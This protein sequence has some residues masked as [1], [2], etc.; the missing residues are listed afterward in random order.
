MVV[1]FLVRTFGRQ[2]AD[3]STPSLCMIFKRNVL[4]PFLWQN[5]KGY[6]SRIRNSGVRSFQSFCL[7][8]QYFNY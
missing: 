2:L 8:E 6:L 4:C 1:S 3:L 7:V 5:S